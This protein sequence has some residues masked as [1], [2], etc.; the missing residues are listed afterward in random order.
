VR[1]SFASNVRESA[2]QD[3][4]TLSVPPSTV[5]VAVGRPDSPSRIGSEARVKE[6]NPRPVAHQPPQGRRTVD[7]AG[8]PRHVTDP[9]C[10]ET[11]ARLP[12][13]DDRISKSLFPGPSSPRTDLDI[14][15][16]RPRGT[17]IE[18]KRFPIPAFGWRFLR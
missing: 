14:L 4:A 9:R 5:P 2:A 3:R 12:A 6:G 8:I 10:P 15:Q 18:V 7:D 17:A 13:D 16:Y 11:L 1:W